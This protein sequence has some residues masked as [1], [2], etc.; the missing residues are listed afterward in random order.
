M[1]TSPP[2]VLNGEA[3]G[4]QQLPSD[5]GSTPTSNSSPVRKALAKERSFADPAFRTLVYLCA[6]AVLA[7]VGLIVYE[8]LI[9]SHLAIS[10]FGF[11]FLVKQIWDPVNEDFGALPFVYG[12]L[13]S[14]LLALVI[15]GA[16]PAAQPRAPQGSDFPC[17]VQT[18]ERIVAVGDVHGAFDQFVMFT[19]VTLRPLSSTQTVVRTVVYPEQG[20]VFAE[21]MEARA[22]LIFPRAAQDLPRS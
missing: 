4:K 21:S 16:R 20:W 14:S 19:T 8:L 15:A 17:D 2:R 12:T 10:K 6:G 5:E 22:A 3:A 7:I 11:K 9:Q 1:Q 18:P 13:V